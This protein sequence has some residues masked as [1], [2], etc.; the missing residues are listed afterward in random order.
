V[1]LAIAA[2]AGI[3]AARGPAAAAEP[4]R[5]AVVTASPESDPA[6]RYLA[7]QLDLPTLRR[8]SSNA[9]RLEQLLLEARGHW[10]EDL[11]VV[12]DAE[13]A[14]VSVIRPS[15]GTIS[16]RTLN[17]KAASAPY[18]VA[19]AAVELLELVRNAPPAQTSP[20]PREPP[21]LRLNLAFDFGFM[22]SGG[23]TGGIILVE[24]T[25]GGDL[26]LSPAGSPIWWVAGIHGSGLIPATRDFT[27]LLPVVQSRGTL[28][29][30]RDELSVRLGLGHRDG[31]SAVFGWADVGLAFI[32]LHA[33]DNAGFF[34]AVDRR[35]A[36]WLGVGAE[37]R[38]NVIGS[39]ALGLGA[40]VA[41][42]PVAS[43]FFA[44]PPGSSVE[45]TA[46]REDSVDLRARASVIWEFAP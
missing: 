3:V 40:G 35:T 4:V 18:A 31:P 7:T 14:K 29:Y 20:M 27:L 43:R 11:I 38:Y 22:L 36:I 34:T 12:V 16:S 17:E 8:T 13:R 24:P 19:L 28:D 2:A 1:A 23:T 30:Q 9:R 5:V 26:E 39:F 32:R 46:L 45:V 37:L 15:D 21:A 10:R 33:Q 25:L 42:L 6:A 41:F 44:S